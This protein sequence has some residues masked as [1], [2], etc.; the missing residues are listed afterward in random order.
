VNNSVDNAA[1]K[2][3]RLMAMTFPI[4]AQKNANSPSKIM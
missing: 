3:A 4:N 2:T 1:P